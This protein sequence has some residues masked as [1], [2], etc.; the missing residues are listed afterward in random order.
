MRME[1]R[2]FR[3]GELA[4]YLN[5]ERFVIRFWEKEFNIKSQRSVGGQRFYNEDDLNKFKAVKELLYEKRFTIAGA[6]QILKKGNISTA[7]EN[8][9]IIA[10]QITTFEQSSS[11]QK[12][13]PQDMI[14]KLKKLR[15]ALITFKEQ[16]SL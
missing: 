2:K 16:I 10:S 15:K 4:N 6:K 1:K 7:K 8:P 11:D 9:K 5:V 14:E 12:S 3:I 13:L